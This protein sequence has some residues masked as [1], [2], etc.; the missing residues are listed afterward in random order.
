MGPQNHR[1]ASW[2]G[3]IQKTNNVTLGDKNGFLGGYPNFSYDCI[4]SGVAQHVKLL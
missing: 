3:V 1:L 4:R 2:K